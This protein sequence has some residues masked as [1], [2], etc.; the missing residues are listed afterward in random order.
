MDKNEFMRS[1]DLCGALRAG[2]FAQ[3]GLPVLRNL[4]GR[5]YNALWL[6]EA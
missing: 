5:G 4:R 6:M 3:P 1:Q 2:V